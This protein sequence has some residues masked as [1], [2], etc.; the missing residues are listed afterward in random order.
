MNSFNMKTQAAYNEFKK[1]RA[2]E[3]D[4]QILRYKNRTKELESNQKLEICNFSKILKGISSKGYIFNKI[5]PNSRI[6]NIM[7]SASN[8]HNMQSSPST[9]NKNN[10]I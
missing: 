9:F 10:A 7:K 4:K 5:G 2:I 8:I 3:F 6:S 1:N